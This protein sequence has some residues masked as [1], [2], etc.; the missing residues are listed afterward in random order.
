M[1]KKD[2]WSY[3]FSWTQPYV[4]MQG[5]FT[6]KEQVDHSTRKELDR[7]ASIDKQIDLMDRYPDAE[8]MIE[9]LKKGYLE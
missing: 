4:E 7:I 8:A 6:P 3:D 1:S 2:T 9:R 5:F